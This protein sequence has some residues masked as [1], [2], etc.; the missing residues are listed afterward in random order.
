MW[1]NLILATGLFVGPIPAGAPAQEFRQTVRLEVY[2]PA[3]A[4]LSIEGR[5]TRSQGPKRR[6]VSAP[7]PPGKY[8]Y[9]LKAIVPGPNGPQ[10][11]TRRIDVRPGD[12]E[13]ID[14]RAPGERPIADVEYEPTPQPVV[15]ALLRLAKTTRSDVLWDLGCGDGRIPVTAAKEYGCQAR[16]FDIDPQRVKDS[17][18]NARRQGVRRRVAIERR[19]IFTLD[20]S[21]G[22]TI[23]TLYLLPRLN[24]QLLPQLRQL[25][26]GAR[27]V[28]VA[29]RLADIPPDEQIVVDTELGPF[30]VYLWNAE[31]L[32][33]H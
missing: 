23:V 22:P 26:P 19:D 29:H 25:P 5:L 2:L 4:R 7:L 24:A 32:R 10:T 1:R 12:F 3:C 9:T 8:V 27:V 31:T 13:S 16:G 15:D 21:E 28:S 33:G 30:D 6:F 18:D 14:L 17:L 20:L 11:I